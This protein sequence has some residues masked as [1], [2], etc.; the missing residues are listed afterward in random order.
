MKKTVLYFLAYIVLALISTNLNAQKAGEVIFLQSAIGNKYLDVQWGSTKDGTPLHLWPYNGGNAQKFKLEAAGGKYFYIK[1]VLGKYLH[2]QNRSNQP[3]AKV[4]LY[5]G[6]GNPNTKWQFVPG[7]DGYHYIRSQKGTYMDVQ[8]GSE[9]DGTPIWMWNYNGGNAQR[10]KIKKVQ[11]VIVRAPKGSENSGSST[12]SNTNLPYYNYHLNLSNDR[13]LAVLAKAMEERR[14]SAARPTAKGVDLA[15][16]AAQLFI[17]LNADLDQRFDPNESTSFSRIHAELFVD[18]EPGSLVFYYRPNSYHLRWDKDMGKHDLQINYS[19]NTEGTENKS[20]RVSAT[21]TSG[22][23]IAEK[24]FMTKMLNEI[25]RSSELPNPDV[26]LRPLQVEDPEIVFEGAGFDINA[27]QISI[28]PSSSFGDEIEVNFSTSDDN[29]DALKSAGLQNKISFTVNFNYKEQEGD[30]GIPADISIMDESTYGTFEVDFPTLSTIQNPTPYPIMVQYL[31]VLTTIDDSGIKPYIFSFDLGDKTLQPND[32]LKFKK[33]VG[34]RVPPKLR[35][36][37]KPL[38]AFVEYRI[39][40]C[41]PCTQ[42]IF[43][44]LTGGVT[45][46]T[47][48][49]IKFRSV[50]LLKATGAEFIWVRMKSKQLD[51]GKQ[52]EVT[53]HD[54]IEIASDSDYLKSPTLYL[55][56]GEQPDFKY[57]VE[58][59][60]PDGEIYAMEHWLKGD[61][62]RVLLSKAK[63]KEH[64][65]SWP[66]KLE[67]EEYEGE[68]GN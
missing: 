14:K 42:A 22:I 39:L 13:L 15:A 63:L 60:M 61:E 43:N 37:K 29:I 7:P 17:D 6:R 64:F 28:V 49:E 21:L 24:N 32:Q 54:P 27:D 55:Y 40:E 8:W 3:K 16:P 48:Q 5:Q 4:V 30:V 67:E 11:Q 51:P 26:K 44:D 65:N 20:A 19:R 66:D 56:N 25:L 57:Q 23:T 10:W 62:L 68:E 45:A 2:V 18:K 58:L 34:F 47:K 1:S 36:V 38:R 35:S 52:R 31:H 59:V 53:T 33:P 12:S 9:K 41:E 46:A 50:N